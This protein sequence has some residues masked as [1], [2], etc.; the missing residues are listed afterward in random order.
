MKSCKH[1][2]PLVDVLKLR[3]GRVLA[4]H[5]NWSEDKGYTGSSLYYDLVFKPSLKT[6][7]GL[8]PDIRYQV[9]GIT[10]QYAGFF[11]DRCQSMIAGANPDYDPSNPPKWTPFTP[12]GV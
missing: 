4:Q 6:E 3:G 5:R 10:A 7:A 1:L 12:D 2:Q 11:C 9:F 8:K